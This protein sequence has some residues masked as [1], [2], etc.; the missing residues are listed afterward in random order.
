MLDLSLDLGNRAGSIKDGLE[1]LV[2]MDVLKGQNKYRCEKYVPFYS[3]SST[4]NFELMRERESVGFRCKKLVVAEKQ[5]LIEK[6][7]L[8]L[9]IHLK[10]FTPT[11]RKVGGFIKYPEV[12]NLKGYMTDVRLLSLS[13]SLP[14]KQLTN[15]FGT[16]RRTLHLLIDSTH[17]SS[18]PV[19]V[20]IQATIPP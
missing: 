9:T 7:P 14:P 10:R 8:V 3:A 11:G 15:L 5:F 18:T 13:L 19:Q 12:L 6:S 17:S 2:R 1:N 4:L 16:S 20:P